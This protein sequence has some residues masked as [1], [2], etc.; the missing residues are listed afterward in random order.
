MVL[1]G[2]YFEGND[3]KTLVSKR[4]LSESTIRRYRDKNVEVLAE[5]YLTLMK[6]GAVIEW[7]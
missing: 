5:M 3:Q 1:Q 6:A 2:L 4:N 7:E